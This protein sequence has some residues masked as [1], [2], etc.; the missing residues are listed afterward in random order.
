MLSR[1]PGAKNLPSR[2]MMMPAMITPKMSTDDPFTC[3]EPPCSV[4]ARAL[5][6]RQLE[7]IQHGES[8]H[9][10]RVEPLI[11]GPRLGRRRR[12]DPSRPKGASATG[13]ARAA[14][15]AAGSR[16]S[17]PGWPSASTS[18]F[19]TVRR[20]RSLLAERR[21]PAQGRRERGRRTRRHDPG[22]AA[23]PLPSAAALSPV[24]Q[25]VMI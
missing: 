1:S 9:C 10:R 3:W 2:P 4:T 24:G 16:P 5:A 6:G 17:R 20:R 13:P 15:A 23:V 7:E 8:S 11:P 22:R 25:E 12:A 21:G 18:F 14:T 19:R